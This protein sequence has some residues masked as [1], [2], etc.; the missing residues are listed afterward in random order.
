MAANYPGSIYSPRTKENKAGVVY[1][2]GKTT[3][4]FAEDI[5]KLDEEVVAI[6]TAL[7]TDIKGGFADLKARIVDLEARVTALEGG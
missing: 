1:D 2:A 4:I 6:E 5:V 3:L 7:G